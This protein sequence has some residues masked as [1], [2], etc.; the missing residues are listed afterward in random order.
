MSK[1]SSQTTALS[2]LRVHLRL[3]QAQMARIAGCTRSMLQQI[4]LQKKKLPD[5]IAV[6]IVGATGISYAWLKNGDPELPMIDEFGRPYDA[7]RF[8]QIS[9]EST[10]DRKS[11]KHDGFLVMWFTVHRIA[12]LLRMTLG[13]IERDS[14]P[15]LA[16]TVTMQFDRWKME[17]QFRP[18]ALLSKEAEQAAIQ[19]A[20]REPPD[21]NRF[22]MLS[23]PEGE[24]AASG[25]NA[26]EIANEARYQQAWA[27]F[28]GS[29][30]LVELITKFRDE[31]DKLLAARLGDQSQPR[32][33]NDSDR[34]PQICTTAGQLVPFPNEDPSGAAK[35]ERIKQQNAVFDFAATADRYRNLSPELQ[36]AKLQ[37]IK[38][39]PLYPT[40][41]EIVRKIEQTSTKKPAV[42]RK[43]SGRR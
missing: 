2:R 22:S 37:K 7:Q 19:E 17:A 14:F 32:R 25:S 24:T 9:A 20:M 18:S 10:G 28:H 1:P 3:K 39:N 12:D 43:R 33:G 23:A 31:A 30:K 21:P 13:S 36:E 11:S 15:C 16:S 41:R 26:D 29:P 35:V 5:E 42:P 40:I 27:D 4:E 6:R 38:M 8:S 34:L